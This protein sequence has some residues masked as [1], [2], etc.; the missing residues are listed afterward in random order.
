M[1]RT[2]EVEIPDGNN[3]C[4]CSCLYEGYDD[5]WM[6]EWYFCTLYKDFVE[7]TETIECGKERT[8]WRKSDRCLKENRI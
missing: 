6:S 2:V 1:K 8:L 7:V 3:C 4:G 5:Y